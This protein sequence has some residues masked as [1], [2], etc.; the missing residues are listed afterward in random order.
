MVGVDLD[1]V[2]GATPSVSRCVPAEQIEDQDPGPGGA[3][4]PG[5][6]TRSEGRSGSDTGSD[7]LARV[8]AALSESMDV[9]EPEGAGVPEAEECGVDA[10]RARLALMGLSFPRRDGPERPPKRGHGQRRSRRRQP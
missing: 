9:A 6:G 1:K 2:V 3:P 7:R 8:L 10:V 4:L 5:P